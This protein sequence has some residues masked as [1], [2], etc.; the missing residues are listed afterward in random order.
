MVSKDQLNAFVSTAEYVSPEV[1][2]DAPATFAVDL[3]AL[4][5]ITF[6]LLVGRPPFQ[7]GSEYLTFQQIMHYPETFS[8]AFPDD[9]PEPA[10]VPCAQHVGSQRTVTYTRLGCRVC[11][12]SLRRSW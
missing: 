8:L 2:A 9:F 5:C 12:T 7:G 10:K 4:G 3:W 6:Q 1:L 11:R